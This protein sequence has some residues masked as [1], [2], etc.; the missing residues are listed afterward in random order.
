MLFCDTVQCGQEHD[1]AEADQARFSQMEGQADN[2]KQSDTGLDPQ[3]GFA[4]GRQIAVFLLVVGC[5]YL[6]DFMR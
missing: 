4:T 2:Q 1:D 3:L 5:Q 6:T